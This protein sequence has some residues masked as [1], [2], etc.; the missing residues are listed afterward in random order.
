MDLP[1]LKIVV[2]G[3]GAM[4]CLLAARLATTAAVIPA[5]LVML[6]HWPEQMATLRQQGLTLIHPDGRRSQQMVKATNRLDEVG[7]VD[8]ALVVVKSHQTGRAAA[9]VRQLLQPD[10]L[11]LTLQNG[12]G[13]LETL[14]VAV[15]HARVAAGVTTEG[16]TMLAPGVVR[17]AGVGPTHLGLPPDATPSLVRRLEQAAEFLR[18]AGFETSI[19]THLDGLIWG[20]LAV[21]AAINP[22]TA[23]LGVANGFLAENP[24]TRQIMLA[25]AS[26]T[27]VVAAALG[28][29]LPFADA[30]RQALTVA[31]ATAANHSSM[32]QDIRRGAPT[33][34][35]AISGAIVQQ[36]N[37]LNIAAPV[38]EALWRFVRATEAGRQELDGTELL[39]Q[40]E[41]MVNCGP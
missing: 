20:K 33:E 39:K 16:A 22:L 15:G 13:N 36:A 37:R 34:I 40:L 2:V 11:A 18:R 32:L 4:G 25:A 5:N 26:E 19:V 24:I 6:G 3:S 28:I 30:G 23:V 7:P 9:E 12:L 38:N 17:H 29:D 21:S 8:L 10:G 35:E 27:A 31:Q 14:R 1:S 41:K